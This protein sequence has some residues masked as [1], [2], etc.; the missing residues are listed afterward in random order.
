MRVFVFTVVTLLT[1]SPA[2]AGEPTAEQLLARYDAIMGPPAF[3]S[4]AEMTAV[5]EDGT[6]R[7]Y[8]MRMLRGEE[9]KFRVWFLGPASAKGQEML[10]SGDNLWVY[11]PTLKRAT[12]I[13]NRDSFQGGDFNNADVMRV[14]YTR[15]Y[16]A[17][18]VPSSVPGTYA[19]QLKAR[20]AETAYDAIRLWVREADGQPVRG[21]YYGTSGQLLRTAE[22]S[23]YTEFDKGYT[24]PA[25]VVM[26][27]A[28]VTAR[29]S[30]FVVHSLRL[31]VE[32]PAQRFTQVDLGR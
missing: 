6:A 14:N 5:R 8:V 32:V 7:T 29:R 19:L 11:L 3:E 23:E 21:E 4:E 12:R 31:R 22:F 13:A 1:L 16:S 9:D 28:L 17:E 20:T 30:E 15:D 2:Q 27:N 26:H 10:R 18:R 25:R 24:R